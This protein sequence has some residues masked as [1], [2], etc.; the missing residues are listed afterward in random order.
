MSLRV[1]LVV[2]GTKRSGKGD[3]SR[4]TILQRRRSSSF[5]VRKERKKKEYIVGSLISLFYFF[6]II[7]H[8]VWYLKFFFFFHVASV[9][10]T[11]GAIRSINWTFGDIY[12]DV[13]IFFVSRKSNSTTTH[14]Y[15]F[16]YDYED[17]EFYYKV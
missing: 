16:L 10:L 13:S 5:L 14:D 4:D 7:I 11:K 9:F 1:F 17:L 8:C 12:V 2:V 15:M 6:I 3:E